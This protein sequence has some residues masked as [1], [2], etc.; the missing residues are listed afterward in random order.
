L[1]LLQ[2]GG[3]PKALHEKAML[4]MREEQAALS[5]GRHRIVAV[6][7]MN[8]PVRPGAIADLISSILEVLGAAASGLEVDE[9]LRGS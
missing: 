2:I 9:G 1:K 7:T 3:S 4:P 8:L 5:R 6:A